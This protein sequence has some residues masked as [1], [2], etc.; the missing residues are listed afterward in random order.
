MHWKYFWS[1]VGGVIC[2]NW[3]VNIGSSYLYILSKLG[4]CLHHLQHSLNLF[5]AALPS[6]RWRVLMNN[7]QSSG[8][9]YCLLFTKYSTLRGLLTPYDDKTWI[10]FDPGNVLLPDGTEQLLKQMFTNHHWSLAAFTVEQFY[11]KCSTYTSLKWVWKLL[12]DNYC[13]IAQ[14]PMRLKIVKC[15]SCDFMQYAPHLGPT[16]C[17]DDKIIYNNDNM[18]IIWWE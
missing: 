8:F 2:Q 3:N 15:H 1:Y 11:T 16:C 4:W 18:M 10:R 9:H 14:G 13:R 5:H 6:A 12:I 17:F 7:S